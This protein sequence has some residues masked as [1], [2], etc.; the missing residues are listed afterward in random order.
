[1]VGRVPEASRRVERGRSSTSTWARSRN[2]RTRSLPGRATGDRIS[3]PFASRGRSRWRS[4]ASS[5]AD[6]LAGPRWATSPR[7]CRPV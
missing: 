6:R 3:R 4:C 1:M 7:P 2:S 5:L